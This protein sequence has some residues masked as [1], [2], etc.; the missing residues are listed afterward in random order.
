MS[1]YL[2]LGPRYLFLMSKNLK[3][4]LDNIANKK[5]FPEYSGK[6]KI[7]YLVVAITQLIRKIL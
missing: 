2:L 3:I 5:L 1:K 4:M 6:K 7:S